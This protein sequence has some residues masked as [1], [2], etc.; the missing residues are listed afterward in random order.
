MLEQARSTLP[1]LNPYYDLDPELVKKGKW[2]ESVENSMTLGGYQ[3]FLPSQLQD[4][5]AAYK[6]ETE[7]MV[8]TLTQNLNSQ[9]EKNVEVE[10]GMTE[11]DAKQLRMKIKAEHTRME[12]GDIKRNKKFDMIENKRQPLLNVEYK[13]L[14]KLN[15]FSE[16]KKR[17]ESTC[18]LNEEMKRLKLEEKKKNERKPFDNRNQVV[19]YAVSKRNPLGASTK[20]HSG[21]S[22]LATAAKEKA[23]QL[24]RLKREMKK[25]PLTE[26]EYALKN[27]D[28]STQWNYAAAEQHANLKQALDNSQASVVSCVIEYENTIQ[29]LK[30]VLISSVHKFKTSR[31]VALRQSSFDELTALLGHP[32]GGRKGYSDWRGKSITGLLTKTIE[33]IESVVKWREAVLAAQGKLGARNEYGDLINHGSPTPFMWN[34][35]NVLLMIPRGLDFLM[36]SQ[37]LVK[38]YGNDFTFERN[39]FMLAV[40]LDERP[41][42]PIKDTRMVVQNGEKVEQVSESLAKISNKQKAYMAR[43]QKVFADG[44]SWWPAEGGKKVSNILMRRI[45][46]AE[47][48]LH[49]E[50]QNNQ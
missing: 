48:V 15:E 33:L 19:E 18:T 21:P 13:R 36:K 45:R 25:T 47:K 1:P 22:P 38:W 5:R 34:G 44:G 17:W 4:S 12:I 26:L 20:K 27:V 10:M 23:Q 2:K 9:A 46:A 14:A 8:Q 6:A 30:K 24:L 42:T 31:V 37:E 41:D 40:P 29:N 49:L 28:S 35:V 3:N 32:Q 50:E 7:V 43:C 11:K 16:L 39:P